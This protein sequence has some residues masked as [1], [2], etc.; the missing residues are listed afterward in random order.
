MADKILA[1]EGRVKVRRFK[2]ADVADRAAWPPYT[3][4]LFTHLNMELTTFIE[5]EKWLFARKTNSGRMYFAI[6]DESARLIGEMSLRDVDA[7]AKTSRLGIHLASDKIGLG[8]GREA[9]AALLSHYFSN[10]SWNVLLLDVAAFNR[11]ALRLYERFHF[12]HVGSFWRRIIVDDSI[13]AD[14]AYA[15]IRHLL[16]RASTGIEALHYDMALTRETYFEKL[17]LT[18]A[19]GSP[20]ELA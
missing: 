11:R 12:R 6:E 3:D 18:K 5:R 8:Y 7:Y 2:R 9:L 13:M 14:P 10:M 15:P 4:P 19:A 17:A 20:G 16:R 1:R